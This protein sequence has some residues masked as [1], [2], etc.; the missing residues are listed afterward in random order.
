MHATHVVHCF[1]LKSLHLKHHPLAGRQHVNLMLTDMLHAQVSP[2]PGRARQ[3][4]WRRCSRACRSGMGRTTAPTRCAP[5]AKSCCG[6][7]ASTKAKRV[8]LLTMAA[9]QSLRETLDLTVILLAF[10][11]NCTETCPSAFQFGC[12]LSPKLR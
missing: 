11:C 4:Q 9:G 6:T 5:G 12:L 3:M 1:E 10:Y 2:P 7:P 8:D